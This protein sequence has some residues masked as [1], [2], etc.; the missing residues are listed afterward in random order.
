MDNARK[1]ALIQAGIDID[2]TL[3][4]F[5]NNEAL[6]E[7]FWQKFPA[8]KSYAELMDAIASDDKAKAVTSIHTFKGVCGTLGFAE[9]YKTTVQ[10]EALMRSGQWTEA[11]D[12]MPM[13][14]KLYKHVCS[15]IGA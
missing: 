2:S 1:E 10:I 7:R 8:D 4:R 5:M 15:V 14:E 12:A 6:M 11:L 9:M 3:E 13:L